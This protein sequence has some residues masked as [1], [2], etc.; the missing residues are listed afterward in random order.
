MAKRAGFRDVKF[1]RRGI[2]AKSSI[3]KS[4]ENVKENGNGEIGC[5]RIILAYL[6]SIFTDVASS[7]FKKSSIETVLI[8][9]KAEAVD[10]Y[11][12]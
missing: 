3:R 4:I 2:H 7:F 8:A 9:K 12:I 6:V 11:S 10:Q 5:G 1:K